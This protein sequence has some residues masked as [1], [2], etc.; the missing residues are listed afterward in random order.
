M[1]VNAGVS[2]KAANGNGGVVELSPGTT[3]LVAIAH[4]LDVTIIATAPEPTM[5]TAIRL[6]D[7]S[8]HGFAR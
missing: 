3:S 4:Q 8:S 7:P 2:G 1:P 6:S 5:N